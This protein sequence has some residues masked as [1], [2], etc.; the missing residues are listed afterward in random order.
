VHR[1]RLEPHPDSGNTPG[2]GVGVAIR[3]AEREL[4]LRYTIEADIARLR[5][6][7][8]G[9][10]RIGRELW[11]HTCCECFIALEGRREYHEFNFSP[12]RDWAA[13]AF[14]NYR[15]GGP[16]M[17][18]ALDPRIAVLR[19]SDRL[20][21]EASIPLERLSV[22]YPNSALILGLSAVIEDADGALSYWAL[23]HPTAKPDFHHRGGFVLTVAAYGASSESS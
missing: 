1:V 9:V 15:E 5:V 23:K 8:E 10:P 3:R 4:A 20:A 6:P 22:R 16:L 12:S 13:Y 17:D 11:K 2:G 7:R 18:E 21:L 19:F 14:S